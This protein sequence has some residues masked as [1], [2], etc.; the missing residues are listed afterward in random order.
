MK[1]YYRQCELPLGCWELNS[2]PL[3][4]HP[5]LLTPEPS[6]QALRL[7]F[8]LSQFYKEVAIGLTQ[9]ELRVLGLMVVPEMM[10]VD[11]TVPTLAGGC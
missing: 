7:I 4:E 9:S 10:L 6:L 8:K 11:V 1:L 3:E 2:G 5:M